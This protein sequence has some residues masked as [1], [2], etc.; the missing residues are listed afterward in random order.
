MENGVTVIVWLVWLAIF[1]LAIP[2]VLRIRH[3]EQRAFAAYLIFVSIFTVVAGVLFW[4][5]SW[6][7]L[8]L[9]LAPML[10]RVIPAIVFLLLIFVPA[11]ALAFWQARKPR[12]R[13][14]PPP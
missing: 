1:L 6:L 4:L 7:A 8:A 3:P 12:W 9:G 2:L 10:E 5:L 14:A 13:K 11:F